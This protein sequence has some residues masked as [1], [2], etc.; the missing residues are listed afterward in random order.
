MIIA[1]SPQ[2]QADR[3]GLHAWMFDAGLAVENMLIQGYTMGM[4]IHA[5]GG[6]DEKKLLASFAIPEPFRIATVIAAGWRGTVESL[7]EEVRVKD[8][9][10]RTRKAPAEFVFADKFGN[11]R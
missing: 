6:F 2:E 4:T 7:P 1:G 10:P 9:K 3:N 8:E 5:M 11:A